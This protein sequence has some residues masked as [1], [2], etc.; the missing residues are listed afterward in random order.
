MWIRIRDKRSD[1]SETSMV[2][3]KGYKWVS[4]LEGKILGDLTIN[5]R[6]KG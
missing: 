6:L 4:R 1:S 3:G 2:V 5:V